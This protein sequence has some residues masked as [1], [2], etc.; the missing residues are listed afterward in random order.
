MQPESQSRDGTAAPVSDPQQERRRYPRHQCVGKVLLRK[1]G[2]PVFASAKLTD[3]ALG[4]CYAET[5]SPFALETAVEFLIQADELEIRGCGLVRTV[6]PAMGNGIAFT[7][8][9]ADDWRRLNEL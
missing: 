1:E 8:L 7:Q 5:F 6:H 2:T 9:A 4:G 3:V